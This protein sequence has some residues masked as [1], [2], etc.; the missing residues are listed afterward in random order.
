METI[1]EALA[2]LPRYLTDF[3]SVLM[4]PKRFV[5]QRNV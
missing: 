2:Y 4:G 1:R 5:A 3:G